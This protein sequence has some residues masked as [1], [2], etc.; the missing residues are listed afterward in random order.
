MTTTARELRLACGAELGDT[1]TMGH[2]LPGDAA[3]WTRD[4]VVSVQHIDA[5]L[6]LDLASRSIEGLVTHTVS[7]MNDGLAR[8]QFDAVEMTILGATVD[9]VKARHGYDGKTVTVEFTRPKSR[10]QTI[11]VAIT[12]R[13]TP[14]VGMYFISPDEGYPEKPSQVWTQCQDEDTRFWLPCIDFP[15]QKQ[16]SSMA[17]TVPGSW[18]ALSNGTLASTTTNADGTKTYFWKQEQPHSTYLLTIAAGEFE[19]ID[20]SRADLPIDYYVEPG[21]AA[22]GALTFKN[23]PE[24][25]ASFERLT[26]IAYPWAKYSQIVV[27]D[28]VFGGMENTSATT[29]TENILLD[30]KAAKDHT[31]DG[32]I[33]HELAHMWFGDLMTCR[34]WSHG[35]LN[36]SFAT[37]LE[38]L[39]DEERKG[40]DEYL[41]G[42]MD[43]TE[44]YFGERYR[45]PIVSNVFRE[46]IDLFDRHLYEKG[47]VVLHMLRG[48][49]GDDQFFRAIRRYCADNRGRSVITQDLIDAIDAETGRNLE[50]FF[51]QWVFKPGHP[52]LVVAWQWDDATNLATVTVKQTQK[53]DAGTPIFRLPLTIDFQTGTGKPV[54]FT[55]ELRDS[56]QSFVFALGSRPDLC[57]FDPGNRVMKE[58]EFSKSI[59][60]LRFQLRNDKDAWDRQFAATELGKKGGSDAIASLIDALTGDRVWWVRAAAAKALGEAKGEAARDALLAATK[61][62]QLKV[63]RAV[64]AALGAFRG[65]ERVFAALEPIAA[66]DQSWFV[67]AEANR[68]I[69]KLRVE[70]SFATIEGNLSRRSFREVVRNGCLDGLVELRDERGLALILAAAKYGAPAQSR[71]TAAG[72]IARLGHYFGERTAELGEVLATYL[73]DKDF[74]VRLAA[75]NAFRVLKDDRQIASLDKM[76]QR[77][78]DGRGVRVAREV[79]AVLR[80]GGSDNESLQTLRDEMEQLQEAN[81]K[82]RE[83]M[84]RIEVTA[85]G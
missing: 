22:E 2:P 1:A 77:E 4:R 32:L 66:R 25:I 38:L 18:F 84:E 81:R 61:T 7:P 44:S 76:A 43:N 14:R 35:W 51:D 69:G 23:T 62:P 15:N 19:R 10:E 12:Y 36:E 56:E 64:V 75:A 26:G 60:E 47:S 72:A 70:G 49:L 33:S 78:L 53:T 31:S 79:A 11:D 6:R 71:P 17:V 68:S 82:L 57:R 45:R 40:A 5:A 52:K 30:A 21:K 59:A 80:A 39:W 42:V 16:T 50:W 85:K 58:I 73:E 29:M 13:A 27:R 8:V 41:H 46:P 48:V 67:E 54:V 9:G 55:T 24:M 65:D 34:D 3:V 28:F 63:R 83:R 74:R 20:A 37:Y